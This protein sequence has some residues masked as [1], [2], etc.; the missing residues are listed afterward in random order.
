MLEIKSLTLDIG[1]ERI[2][3][4]INLKV[5]AGEVLALCGESGAG[6]T[7]LG[8]TV[9]G[10]M[11]GQ[12]QGEVIFQGRNLLPLAEEEWRRL[13]GREMAMVLQNTD[14]ALNPVLSVGAQLLEA[15]LAHGLFDRAAAVLRVEELLAQV[16]L[17]EHKCNSYP[18][19]LS[20][21]ERARVLLAM[22]LANDPALLILDEPTAAVDTIT[23]AELLSLIKAISPGRAVLLIT[24]D[25]AAAAVAARI[26]VMYGGTLVEVGT[27]PAVLSDPRHPYT[28]GLLR[29]FPNMTTVKDLQGIGG[30]GG[31]APGCPFHPRCTQRLALCGHKI[32]ALQL[33]EDRWLACHRGGIVPLLQMRNL[34]KAF[35][36]Q[37]AVAGVDLTLQEGESLAV[38][39]ETG[40][41]KTTLARMIMNLLPP[42][43]GQVE[44]D[45]SLADGAVQMV[46]QHPRASV[47]HRFSALEIV[48]EPL[49]IKGILAD[50][51]EIARAMIAEVHL[52]VDAA[53]LARYPHQL[54]G[55]ELQRLV[56]ARALVLEPKVLVADEPTSA[57]DASTQAKILRLIMALQEKRGL[58]LLLITH[59]LALARKVCDRA[60]VMLQGRIVEEGPAQSVFTQPSH[61]YT[62]A[63]VQHAPQL[64]GVLPAP[65]P[66]AAGTASGGCPFWPRCPESLV[67]C[68]EVNPPL[69][70]DGQLRIACHLV[71]GQGSLAG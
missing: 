22:A 52:P 56:L 49:D 17:P 58:A 25:L 69:V 44:R 62:K 13:R 2:L 68:R 19:Q 38:V 55:G 54:S 64:T 70:A 26:A 27:T 24:H 15:V 30:E 36:G 65:L 53:F 20:G 35:D 37:W 31:R 61:P 21:G 63:M 34:G 39:G 51:D 45:A 8:L 43:C 33:R 4:D 47:S 18:H 48:R 3:R 14:D 71:S 6:K 42:D 32:P 57:L 23:K 66:G 9:M 50:R 12:V 1:S 28:R 59:D 40:S 29:S 16:G 67:V 41:G 46:F 10:L 7:S 11:A 5:A 60:A